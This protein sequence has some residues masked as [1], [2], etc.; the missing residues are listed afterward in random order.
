MNQLVMKNQI[1][2]WVHQRDGLIDDITFGLLQEAKQLAADMAEPFSIVAIA[3][4]IDLN[5]PSDDDQ[6]NAGQLKMLGSGGVDRVIHL[7][8][9]LTSGYHGEY[10]A[11][12]LS[13]IMEKEKP[14][15]FLMAHTADTADL[16]PRLAAIL[17]LQIVTRA[18]DLRV[19]DQEIPTIVRPIANGHLFETLTYNCKRPL[20]VTLLPNILVS[21]ETKPG[22]DSY[23]EESIN[24]EINQINLSQNE[25]QNLK[26][27]VVSIIEAEPEN[28]DITEADIIVAAGRGVSKSEGNENVLDFIYE[29]AG[30]LG[31]SVAGTRPVIDRE[32]LPFERQIGQTGKTVT[33]RLIINCGISGANEYTAGIEK[34]KTIIAINIDP[35]ARIFRFADLGI[36][37]DLHQILP[38][39]TKLLIKIKDIG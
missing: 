3:M 31:G 28:L 20:I 7:K 35:G 29:L 8:G 19:D 10:I 37:G 5:D 24:I 9:S 12:A 26:T 25:Q 22:Q 4:G 16:G 36:V 11:Q 32:D 38:L 34:S 15:F 13:E 30:V 1:W 23:E 2:I 18:V 17:Q 39:L 6:E 33:P 27:K 21:A 14:L